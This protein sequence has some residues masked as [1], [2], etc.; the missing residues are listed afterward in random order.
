[1][2]NEELIENDVIRVKKCLFL[3]TKRGA[4]FHFLSNRMLRSCP[5][6]SAES[7]NPFSK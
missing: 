5:I 6:S 2:K 7:P 4:L 3:P 1:M